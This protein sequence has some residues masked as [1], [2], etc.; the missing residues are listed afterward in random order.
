M[1]SKPHNNH[2]QPRRPHM[3]LKKGKSS[4]WAGKAP[5][6]LMYDGYVEAGQQFAQRGGVVGSP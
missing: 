2:K 4:R 6:N 5:K 3:S 1:S